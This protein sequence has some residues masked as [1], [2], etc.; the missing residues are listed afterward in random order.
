[1]LYPDDGC[2][3]QMHMPDAP[4]PASPVLLEVVWQKVRVVSESRRMTSTIHCT[5][6]RTCSQYIYEHGARGRLTHDDDGSVCY[7]SLCRLLPPVF[8]PVHIFSD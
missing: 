8:A 2:S 1:M 4:V 3:T 5:R 6:G 7:A